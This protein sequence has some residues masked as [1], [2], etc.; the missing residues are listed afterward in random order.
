MPYGKHLAWSLHELMFP[1]MVA[2]N[3]IT[4]IIIRIDQRY[5]ET[6]RENYNLSC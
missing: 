5:L 6:L 2:Y 3:I 1:K 4:M